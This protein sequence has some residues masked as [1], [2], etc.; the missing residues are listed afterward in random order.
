MHVRTKALDDV[1]LGPIGRVRR[2]HAVDHW[3]PVSLDC[4]RICDVSLSISFRGFRRCYLAV[5]FLVAPL[6]SPHDAF[7]H[8][9]LFA[10]A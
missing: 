4:P 2:L 10:P 1:V 5:P 7:A 9:L 6:G 3:V 8:Y